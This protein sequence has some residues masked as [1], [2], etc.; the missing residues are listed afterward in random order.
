M[1]NW[2]LHPMVITRQYTIDDCIMGRHEKDRV[3]ACSPW[4]V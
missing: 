3:A 4:I 1:E 2:D